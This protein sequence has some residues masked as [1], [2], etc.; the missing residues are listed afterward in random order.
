M[1]DDV[2]EAEKTARIVALQSLQ[3]DIQIR[4]HAQ[5][6]GR[7]YEV[8]VDSH[9]RRSGGVAGRTTGNTVV[10]CALPSDTSG[11]GPEAWMGRVVTA[12]ITSAGPHHLHGTIT[13]AAV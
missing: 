11:C 8:L 7:E 2:N 5:M 12:R 10:N 6:V 13:A 4:L 3:R 1:P 9:S